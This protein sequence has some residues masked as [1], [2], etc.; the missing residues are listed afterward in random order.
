MNEPHIKLKDPINIRWLAMENAVK[1]IHQCYGAIVL[2]LQ[3]NEG[4]NTVGDVTANGLLKIVLN[5]KFPAFTAILADILSVVGILCKQLQSESLDLN[6]FLPMR[7]STIGK[8]QGLTDLNGEHMDSFEKELISNGQSISYKGIKLTHSNEKNCIDNMK[9][10]YIKAVCQHI[11]SE[12]SSEST[13]V[14][15]AFSVLNRKQ[16]KL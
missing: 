9:K 13:P 14:L 1:T 12:M 16:M 2:Y 3:S 11:G 5:L 8:L 6:Q 7:E 4:K 15:T 10:D